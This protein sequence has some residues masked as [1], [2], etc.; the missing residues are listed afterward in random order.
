MQGQY[1]KATQAHSPYDVVAWH[2]NYVPYKYD[3][4]KFCVVNSVSY[5]HLDP[6]IFTV[7][8]C[9]STRPGTA[10]A[11]FVIFPPRFAVQQNTFRPPYFHRNVMTEFI[12]LISGHYEA[13]KEGFMPGGA[14]LHSM[15]IP[16]G[17]DTATVKRESCRVDEP[18][19]VA[20]GTMSFMF[21]SMFQMKVADWALNKDGKVDE[22]YY[23][24]WEDMPV[25][26]TESE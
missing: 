1:F 3:L 7:L 10:V 15:A 14:S 12:G 25:T 9:K 17:P 21:E 24:A 26:F 18:E 4:T 2:G 6:S 8:T 13:K 5:D 11:D 19:R 22:N 20:E 23:K 16:H